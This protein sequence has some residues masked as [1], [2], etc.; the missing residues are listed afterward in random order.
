MRTPEVRS[1]LRLQRQSGSLLLTSMK[2]GTAAAVADWAGALLELY[3]AARILHGGSCVPG[4]RLF[5][6]FKGWPGG[7][8]ASKQRHFP[9]RQ[10]SYSEMEA[11]T[12]SVSY[13]AGCLKACEPC[14]F[15]SSQSAE[16]DSGLWQV[17]LPDVAASVRCH[18]ASLFQVL[19]LSQATSLLPP[20]GFHRCT[21]PSRCDAVR[22]LEEYM[23]N[24]RL[25]AFHELTRLL[26][27]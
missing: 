27:G 5:S 3:S 11:I 4:K 13:Y 21:S 18:A 25:Q 10:D 9:C 1:A 22:F 7:Q 8:S 16:A 14:V 12:C 17:P 6:R 24:F 20:A 15:A 23:K 19:P 2:S 26:K